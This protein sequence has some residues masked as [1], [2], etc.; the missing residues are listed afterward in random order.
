MVSSLETGK[1]HEHDNAL[2]VNPLH[3]DL[4]YKATMQKDLSKYVA[5]FIGT[6]AIVFFGTGAVCVSVQPGV[7]LG[8]VGIAVVFSAT[9]HISGAHFNPAVTAMALTTRRISPQIAI[10]YIVAQL[11]GATAA[12]LLLRQIIAPEAWSKVNLGVT[13][14]APNLGATAGVVS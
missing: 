8:L 14:L 5:E 13:A 6:F 4:M 2:N 9:G 11:A 7:Q 10:G 3:G 12:S 1:L